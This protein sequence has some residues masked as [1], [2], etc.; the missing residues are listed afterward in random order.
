MSKTRAKAGLALLSGLG[1]LVLAG[2]VLQ[3][4]VANAATYTGRW[5]ITATRGATHNTVSHT[6]NSTHKVSS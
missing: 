4:G 6:A 1:T 5:S 3:A 2:S